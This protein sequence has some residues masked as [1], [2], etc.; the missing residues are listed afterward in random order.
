MGGIFVEVV[1]PKTNQVIPNP[2]NGGKYTL[3]LL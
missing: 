2:E 1:D 3:D